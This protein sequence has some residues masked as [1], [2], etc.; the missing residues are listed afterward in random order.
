[1]SFD[2]KDTRLEFFAGCALQGILAVVYGQWAN[3]ELLPQEMTEIVASHSFVIAEAM[4]SKADSISAM[5]LAERNKAIAK[6]WMDLLPRRIRSVLS[7]EGLTDKAT[8]LSML[9]RGTLNAKTYAGLGKVG[10]NELC[11]AFGLE[12]AYK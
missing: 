12:E 7:A 8:V 2:P 10:I 11:V 9:E 5:E 1:M 3:K 6:E 4:R